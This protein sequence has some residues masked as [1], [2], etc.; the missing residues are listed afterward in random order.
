MQRACLEARYRRDPNWTNLDI[1]E[2][3]DLIKI[4]FSKV[5]KWNWERK[6]KDER[7]VTFEDLQALYP[8]VMDPKGPREVT[9]DQQITQGGGEGDDG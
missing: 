8:Q 4:P 6:K 9:S 3:A 2:L 5:Y 7:P 1:Q